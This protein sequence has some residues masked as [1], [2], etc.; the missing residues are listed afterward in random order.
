M[1]P[2]FKKTILI[3]IASLAGFLL[4]AAAGWYLYFILQFSVYQD[5]QYKFSIKY[6]KT[7]QVIVHPKPDVAVV[8]MRPKDTA[9]DAFQE[10]FNVTV[11]ASPAELSNLTAFSAMVKTQMTGVFGKRITILEDKPIKFEWRQGHKMVFEAPKPDRLKMVNAWV[12]RGG[13]AYIL[14]FLGQ[15]DKYPKDLLVVNEM[16][17][18][19]KLQ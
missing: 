9:L 3:V 11:Q 15:I 18:S 4:L 1:K 17:R 13:Q 5:I 16:I 7:W 19:L 14:T 6:P 8:F 2:S 10:N 12:L